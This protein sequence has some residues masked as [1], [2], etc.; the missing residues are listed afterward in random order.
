MLHTEVFRE[1]GRTWEAP[2]IDLLRLGTSIMF[3]YSYQG[4]FSTGP[5]GVCSGCA[6][7]ALE[8]PGRLRLHAYCVVCLSLA[9]SYWLGT[10]VFVLLIP[11]WRFDRGSQQYWY[12]W[13]MYP[14]LQ[15]I[16]P[17]LLPQPQ[18]NLFHLH[19]ASLALHICKCSTMAL[20][21][22]AFLGK[23]RIASPP[24]TDPLCLPS[25]SQ[26]D[27]VCPVVPV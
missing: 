24:L 21:Q 4:I 1:I 9:R 5:T 10:S 27:Q 13:L 23:L 15:P 7:T 26:V 16:W 2:F 11:W 6:I 12:C 14:G 8:Q 25:T 18:S 19:P 20:H 3:R 17:S 22:Q